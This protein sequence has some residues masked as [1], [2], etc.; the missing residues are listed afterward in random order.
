[1][2]CESSTKSRRSSGRCAASR[3]RFPRCTALGRL[4]PKSRGAR[5]P[6]PLGPLG[7]H[8]MS[9]IES[10]SHENRQFPPPPA[11]TAQANVKPADFDAL[12][13]E[14]ARDFEGFWARLARATLAWHKPFTRVLD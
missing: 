5:N 6:G 7:V 4:D 8:R 3:A 10:V 13:A 2:L 9:N 12:N 14:V 1:M 11:F